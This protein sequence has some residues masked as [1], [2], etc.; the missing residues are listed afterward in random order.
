MQNLH[1]LHSGVHHPHRHHHRRRPQTGIRIPNALGKGYLTGLHFPED[2]SELTVFSFIVFGNASVHI[3][4][5]KSALMEL[6][7]WLYAFV[8]VFFIFLSDLLCLSWVSKARIINKLKHRRKGVPSRSALFYLLC[9]RW[10][11][12]WSIAF[13][14]LKLIMLWYLKYDTLFAILFSP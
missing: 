1:F 10:F 14:Q 5:L 8:C 3:M 9:S 6:E 2:L 7:I 11:N 13:M 4:Q 12:K